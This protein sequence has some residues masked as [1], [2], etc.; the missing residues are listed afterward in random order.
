M[1]FPKDTMV[2]ATQPMP[3]LAS[4][5]KVTWT[6]SAG[7]PCPDASSAIATTPVQGKEP[8]IAW[9][10]SLTARSSVRGPNVFEAKPVATAMV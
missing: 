6:F 9:R 2:G 10:M 4:Q 3:A 1:Q 8:L 5:T 7:L